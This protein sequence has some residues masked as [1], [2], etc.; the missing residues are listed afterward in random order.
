MDSRVD[1]I[2]QDMKMRIPGRLFYSVHGKYKHC[3]PK[4]GDE[5]LQEKEL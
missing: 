3:T 4:Y 2:Q 1:A 5:E